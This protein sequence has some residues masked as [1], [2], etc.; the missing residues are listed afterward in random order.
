[1]L[2]LG[3]V[4]RTTN[5]L[6]VKIKLGVMPCG[7]VQTGAM[8]VTSFVRDG[9]GLLTI[10]IECEYDIPHTH[11]FPDDWRFGGANGLHPGADP[12][13]SPTVYTYLNESFDEIYVTSAPLC[14]EQAIDEFTLVAANGVGY[15]PVYLTAKRRGE[16]VGGMLPVRYDKVTD[17][18]V[19]IV[20]GG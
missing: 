3:L 19:E 20:R 4:S 9:R 6:N 5:F 12:R 18:V 11:E 15:S 17:T 14:D 8:T 13:W 7:L 1:M 16:L 2:S 10:L